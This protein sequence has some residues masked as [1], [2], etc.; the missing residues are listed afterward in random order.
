[1]RFRVVV[2]NRHR[3]REMRNLI[4]PLG[5]CCVASVAQAQTQAP[6]PQAGPPGFSLD[7]LPGGGAP[8]VPDPVTH[9]KEAGLEA[10]AP[11]LDKMSKEV[12]RGPYA[13]Q[14]GWNIKDP[15]NHVFQ[16]VAGLRN[17]ANKPPNALAAL[18]AAPNPT[19]DCDGVA[20]QVYPVAAPCSVV[21][22]AAQKGGQQLA[23]LEGVRVILDARKT[24][25][26]LLPGVGPNCVVVSVVSYFSAP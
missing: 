11:M 16:S 1:M 9:A 22:D 19:R 7:Q 8:T 2:I 24:R 21:Q 10:C 14:S 26:F 4:L 23:V 3:D 25:L 12:F 17:S 6:R 20:V 5:F 18:I 15:T 13:V